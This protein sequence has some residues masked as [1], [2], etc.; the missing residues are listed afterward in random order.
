MFVVAFFEPALR[1]VAVTDDLML[2][3]DAT[4]TAITAN[5]RSAILVFGEQENVSRITGFVTEQHGGAAV[6]PVNR[7]PALR[8]ESASATWIHICNPD[9]QVVA[10]VIANLPSTFSKRHGREQ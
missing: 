5:P 4:H 9:L 8:D 3:R 6:A 10:S 1:T 2:G 7:P